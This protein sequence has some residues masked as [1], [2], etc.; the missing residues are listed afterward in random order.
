M[1]LYASPEGNDDWSGN[2]PEPNSAG[3]DGPVASLHQAQA[4]VRAALAAGC[5]EPIEVQL[6]EGTYRLTETLVLGPEDSGTDEHRVTWRNYPGERPVLSAAVPVQ[7]WR[8][9]DTPVEGLSAEAAENLWIA[10]L[11]ETGDRFWNF[12]VLFDDQGLMPRARSEP[13]ETAED[14]DETSPTTL[15]FRP[16]DLRAWPNLSDVEI[17]I[18]PQHP[19]DTNY[20]PLESVDEERRLATTTI[21]GTYDLTTQGGWRLIKKP[22]WVENVPEALTQPGE[23]M[24]NTRKR[25]LYLWPRDGGEP[26]N[27]LAPILTEVIRIEGDFAGRNWARG[28]SISGLTFSHGDRMRWPEDRQAVQHDWDLYDFPNA[29]VRLRG[30]EHCQVRDCVFTD[31]GGS[32]VRLDLHAADNQISGNEFARLGGGAISLIGYPPGTRDENHHN[33]VSR[34]HIHHCAERWW[35]S[36]AIL[37]A[38][39]GSNV[40]RNNLVHHMSYSGIVLVSGREGA[41]GKGAAEGGKNG[42][43]INWDEVGHCPA[44]WYHR[45]GFLHCRN[46]LVE[47]NEIHHVMERLGDGNGIYISGTG[48]GNV[49]RRN[50][51]HD[52]EGQGCQ[53]GIRLDDLQWYTTVTENVVWKVSGGGYTTKDINY[54]ENNIAVDCRRWGCILVRRHPAYGS[55]VR[56]NILVQPGAELG[57]PGDQPPFYDGGGFG[58]KLEEPIIE[59]NLLYCPE[60]E[61]AAEACLQSMRAI[62]KDTRSIVADPLFMDLENGDFR[63]RPGSPALKVGFRPIDSWGLTEP[64]GPQS[65]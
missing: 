9:L 34:N 52:I 33:E 63:L 30:A 4:L 53:S 59:D 3:T 36:P 62:G 55:N 58:G 20:L 41:Y 40:V 51:V 38:Q 26:E 27:I 21:E 56:R 25:R 44:E 22:Y 16:G 47:H 61:E 32:G 35:H 54:V 45:L 19:W 1:I 15:V 12:A 60:S 28:I 65:P 39:S 49:A 23:W 48:T 14:T 64:V 17:F 18:F 24:L 7:G 29:A 2:L 6:R 57:V 46:N 50:Y 13:F 37:V 31:S 5:E 11:K 10:D 43:P 8:R 42:R